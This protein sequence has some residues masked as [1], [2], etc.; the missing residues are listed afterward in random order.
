LQHTLTSKKIAGV[1]FAHQLTRRLATAHKP[2]IVQVLHPDGTPQVGIGYE[3]NASIVIA[4]LMISTLH[5][6]GL[7]LRDMR[8]ELIE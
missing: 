2:G 4:T 7:S 1:R 8:H 5:A 6:P 3:T